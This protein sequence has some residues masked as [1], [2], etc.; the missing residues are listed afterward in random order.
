MRIIAKFVVSG[1]VFC[2]LRRN[3]VFFCSVN[4][5]SEPLR[6]LVFFQAFYDLSYSCLLQEYSNVCFLPSTKIP[7]V[8]AI[9]FAI[10]EQFRVILNFVSVGQA[11]RVHCFVICINSAPTQMI[12]ETEKPIRSLQTRSAIQRIWL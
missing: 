5:L 9:S 11:G 6:K 8:I 12:D 3:F 1:C 7:L 4:H 10:L 2:K